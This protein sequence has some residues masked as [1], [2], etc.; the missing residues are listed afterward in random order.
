[1]T[2]YKERIAAAMGG[3]EVS[4]QAVHAL[5]KALGVSYTAIKKVV[6]PEGKSKTLTAENNAKAAKYLR[7][8][9]DWLATGKGEM[10]G[11]VASNNGAAAPAPKEDELLLALTVVAKAIEPTSTIVRDALV[12]TFSNLVRR[13]EEVGTIA[14]TIQ[15]LLGSGPGQSSLIDNQAPAD[16]P[17]GSVRVSDK[18]KANEQRISIPKKRGAL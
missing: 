6:D 11:A 1:M 2:T 5:A 16:V 8:N 14:Q 4:S 10:R 3:P 13:P 7:V 12:P 9:A 17:F 15:N 18:A